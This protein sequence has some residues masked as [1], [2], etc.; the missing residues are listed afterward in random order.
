MSLDRGP[1]PRNAAA[2]ATLAGAAPSLSVSIAEHAAHTGIPS[3]FQARPRQRLPNRREAVTET[4]EFAAGDSRIVSVE[5]S[6]GFDELGRPKEIIFLFGA[7]AGTDMAAVLADTAVSI[8]VALQ[9]RVAAAAMAVTISR[10]EPATG[11]P[12]AGMPASVIGAA[13]DLQRAEEAIP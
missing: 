10:V 9:H 5:A 12:H 6:V 4:V 3:T 2:E 1:P 11:W 13:L 8:S 7:K